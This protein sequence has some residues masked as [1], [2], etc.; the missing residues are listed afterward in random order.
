MTVMD[1]HGMNEDP[2][3]FSK[4]EAIVGGGHGRR[5]PEEGAEADGEQRALDRVIATAQQ[6]QDRDDRDDR[7]EQDEPGPDHDH[8][9]H[10]RQAVDDEIEPGEA[11]PSQR[12]R[13]GRCLG[14][15]REVKDVA[16]ARSRH[17]SPIAI[18]PTGRRRARTTGSA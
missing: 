7:P 5:L 14:R 2:R 10:E 18:I 12:V 6:R 15:C 1:D 8:G 3:S 17:G 13:I 4:S 9:E 11:G 16:V